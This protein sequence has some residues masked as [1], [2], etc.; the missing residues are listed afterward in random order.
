MSREP[1]SARSISLS[2]PAS[3]VLALLV[4]AVLFVLSSLDQRFAISEAIVSRTG[5]ALTTVCAAGASQFR[6]IT[7]AF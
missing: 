1:H 6:P 2:R 7:S 3:C 4:I 5:R